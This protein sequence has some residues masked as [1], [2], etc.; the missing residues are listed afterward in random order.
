MQLGFCVSSRPS[1][2]LYGR[3]RDIFAVLYSAHLPTAGLT[4][5]DPQSLAIRICKPSQN[6]KTPNDDTRSLGNITCVLSRNQF[7]ADLIFV[8]LHGN[9][10]QL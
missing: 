2:I 8:M 6:R 10:A 4:V 3:D 1:D 9:L 7:E 5:L